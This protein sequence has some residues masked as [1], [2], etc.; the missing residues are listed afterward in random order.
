MVK[1]SIVRLGP[2]G[3]NISATLLK[4]ALSSYFENQEQ[5]Q[6]Q[7]DENDESSKVD[8]PTVDESTTLSIVNRYFTANVILQDIGTDKISDTKEDGIILVFDALSSNPDRSA[9]FG[10]DMST[11]AVTFDA[12]HAI[13]EQADAMVDNPPGD[14][15]RLCVGITLVTPSCPEELRGQKAEEEY[16][17]RILWCLDR[18]YEYIEA[19]ISSEG[20]KTGH[21]ERDKEGFA[22]IVEAIQGTMWSSAVM[23]KTQ[24]NVLKKRY[25][26][27]RDQMTKTVN[28]EEL[29]EEENPYEPP[30][31]TTFGGGHPA[32][33]LTST[34]TT[35][36]QSLSTDS[37]TVQITDILLDDS[38]KV[39]P[40]EMEQMTKD[41]QADKIFEQMEGVLREASKIR[42]ASKSG[43]LT[44]Q[45]RRDRAGDAAMALVSLMAQFG[46]DEDDV[47]GDAGSGDDY[48]SDD[49]DSGIA[50][51]TS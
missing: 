26:E 22:R 12:L 39:G 24:T 9:T 13:H 33:T 6:Q 10:T 2:S 18:G 20:Q 14:L 41:L 8:Y 16:S 36:Q 46:I 15:L 30:D 17:R 11:A 3:A 49:D 29:K 27:D 51:V 28:N 31:P 34:D 23:S 40:S 35:T 21:E 5:L 43:A 37:T 38:E 48:S 32:M 7:P 4:T 19:D 50:D 44:D 45:E 47:D 25:Q 42:E 1:S